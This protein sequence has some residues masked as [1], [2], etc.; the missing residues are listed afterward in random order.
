MV[1]NEQE[2]LIVKKEWE[3]FQNVTNIG[4]RADCQDDWKTFLI[5][6]L[7]QLKSWEDNVVDSYLKDLIEAEKAE[8]NL[9][10]E[11]YAYM[12]E[13]TDPAYFQEIR[14]LLPEVPERTLK[15]ID[16]IVDQFMKWEDE[17]EALYPH[18][19]DNGRP[20]EGIG[21][22]GTV[23]VRTYLRSELKTYSEHTIIVYIAQMLMYPDKNRY[24]ISLEHMVQAYGYKSIEEAEKA[25]S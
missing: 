13:D 21:A 5:M 8:R 23:S 10:M 9:V 1:R 24:L 18:V 7:S 6:R 15:M 19:R 4:G 22:D 17:V 16:K 25:L 12:M 3:M 20:A 11:K 14:H 2:Q